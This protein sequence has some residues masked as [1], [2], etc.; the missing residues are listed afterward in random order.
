MGP[1]IPRRGEELSGGRAVTKG[2]R[3]ARQALSM[4]KAIGSPGNGRG[5]G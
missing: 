5:H 3:V 4:P 1:R 2:R